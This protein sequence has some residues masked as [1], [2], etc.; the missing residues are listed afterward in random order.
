MFYFCKFSSFELK[1]L[2][3][4]SGRNLKKKYEKTVYK[5]FAQGNVFQKIKNWLFGCNA[6]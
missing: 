3:N 6:F 5:I 1:F 2:A 4:F